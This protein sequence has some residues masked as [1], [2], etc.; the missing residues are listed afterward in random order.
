MSFLN[1]PFD[2]YYIF[3]TGLGLALMFGS[4]FYTLS[5]L[6]S[7]YSQ[8]SELKSLQRQY[9]T[10]LKVVKNSLDRVELILHDIN[11]ATKSGQMVDEEKMVELLNTREKLDKE[12]G[13]LDDL[14]GQITD[15]SDEVKPKL[16][17]ADKISTY[18]GIGGA[19]LF[20]FGS[21]NWYWKKQR[22]V[23]EKYARKSRKHKKS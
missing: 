15:K 19:I 21:L 12:N 20:V 22:Y 11:N 14:E 18:G 13:I 6:N 23:D 2:D 4:F 16:Q 5:T 7:G 9:N 10:Q 3:N 17:I 1:I 8:L